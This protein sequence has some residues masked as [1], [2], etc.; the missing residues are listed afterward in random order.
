MVFAVSYLY[1]TE[2]DVCV[3][4]FPPQPAEGFLSLLLSA[5]REEPSGGTGHEHQQHN[6]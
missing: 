4:M 3:V 5:L 2:L 6:H 1:G